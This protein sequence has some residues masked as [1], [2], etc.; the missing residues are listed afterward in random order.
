M[1][2]HHTPKG[3]GKHQ[4]L[5]ACVYVADMIAHFMGHGYGHLA[6]ALRGRHDALTILGLTSESIPQFMM[7]A[8]DQMHVVDALFAIAA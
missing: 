5:A 3:A 6:F 7:E 1:C 2:F 8:F 4:R